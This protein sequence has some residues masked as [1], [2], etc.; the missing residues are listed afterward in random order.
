MRHQPKAKLPTEKDWAFLAYIAGDN[1]LS[2][3]GL[4][5]ISELCEVGSSPQVHAAVEI[6]TYGE[7]T[8]SVRYEITEPDHTGVAHRTVI[9]RLPEKD[10]GD[11]ETLTGFARWGL[12]RYPAGKRVLVVW[13]HGSGFRSPR[14]DIAFDDFGSSL[15]MPEVEGALRRAGIGTAEPFG[16]LAILGFDACLMNMA[17]IAHHFHGVT[18][19][20]VGSEQTEPGDGWPYERVLRRLHA[21]PNPEQMAKQIVSDYVAD[22]RARGVEDVTQ[23]AIDTAKMPGVMTA[24]GDLGVE[25]T[26]ALPT[27]RSVMRAARARSQAFEYADYVD[28]LHLAGEL[29]AACGSAAISAAGMRLRNAARK[30][31]V[32]SK[33]YGAS[34]RAATGLSIWFPPEEG[35]YYAHRAKYLRLKCNL[36]GSGWS[37]FLDSYFA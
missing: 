23:S 29:A 1:D 28:M 8:G 16:R 2:A 11:P 26:R 6:D 9:E 34:V 37:S 36:G 17:E 13:N 27:R 21:N 32:A 7:H 20:L 5:D 18:D 24:L 12:E 25:L 10:S 33:V 31:I 19:Y 35:L 3:A 15:D 4:E 14:R 22:Y 30:A